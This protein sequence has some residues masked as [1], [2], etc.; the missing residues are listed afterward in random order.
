MPATPP[1]VEWSHEKPSTTVS[2]RPLP[3]TL[4]AI[5]L[6]TARS[7]LDAHTALFPFVKPS[8]STSKGTRQHHASCLGTKL[9]LSHATPALTK[10]GL[11][12]PLSKTKLRDFQPHSGIHFH[13]NS[14]TLNPNFSLTVGSQILRPKSLCYC[15]SCI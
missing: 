7:I 3:P 9:H 11:Q 8:T 14:Q 5:T 6:P 4:V 10:K 2:L 1:R 13:S 12:L 15:K